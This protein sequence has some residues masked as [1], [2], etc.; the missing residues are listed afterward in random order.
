VRCV[1]YVSPVA[2]L[3][4]NLFDETILLD[5]GAGIVCATDRNAFFNFD[6]NSLA[7]HGAITASKYRALSLSRYSD[8]ILELLQATQLMDE[9]LQETIF[10]YSTT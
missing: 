7:L 2:Y 1:F 8:T 6:E 9:N 3:I 5:D 4:V 10:L